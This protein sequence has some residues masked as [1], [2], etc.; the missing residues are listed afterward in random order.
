MVY[1]IVGTAR[2]KYNHDDS[3][4]NL[5]VR[6]EL[7]AANDDEAL[8][9]MK[10]TLIREGYAILSDGTLSPAQPWES[11]HVELREIRSVTQAEFKKGVPP[12]AA[13]PD[14]ITVC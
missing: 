12:I 2:Y 5:N 9:S 11:L 13:H 3:G 8:A 1:Q 6:L 10:P 14:T 7:E 4:V